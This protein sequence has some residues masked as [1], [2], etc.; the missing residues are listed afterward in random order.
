M[1]REFNVV[2]FIVENEKCNFPL[3]P[4][5]PSRNTNLKCLISFCVFNSVIASLL[6]KEA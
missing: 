4:L 3:L 6:K 5:S 2:P 1:L